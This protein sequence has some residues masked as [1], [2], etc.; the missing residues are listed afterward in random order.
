MVGRRRGGM[1]VVRHL[2]TNYEKTVHQLAWRQL[3]VEIPTFKEQEAERTMIELLKIGAHFVVRKN[4]A[5]II[6]IRGWEAELMA[7]S[8]GGMS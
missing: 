2:L 1:G 6:I 8:S 5:K 3:M 7:A 4:R